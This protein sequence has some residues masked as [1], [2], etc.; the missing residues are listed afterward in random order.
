MASL[1]D[2][3]ARW[4]RWLHWWLLSTQ[5]E[6]HIFDWHSLLHFLHWHL[7]QA[8]SMVLRSA[9]DDLI[10]FLGGWINSTSP[11][12]SPSS[13]LLLSSLLRSETCLRTA[14]ATNEMR[15]H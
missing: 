10:F 4:E 7:M 5:H 8:L 3:A 11:S 9:G 14:N 6:K 12:I 2:L 1:E 15:H 13:L